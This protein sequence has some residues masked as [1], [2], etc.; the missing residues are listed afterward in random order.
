MK[1]EM[2]GKFNP[3]ILLE[4]ISRLMTNWSEKKSCLL[5]NEPG[6]SL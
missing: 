4:F 2:F 6:R 3:E 1:S 5:I